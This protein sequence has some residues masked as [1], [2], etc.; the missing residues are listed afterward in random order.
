MVGMDN[1]SVDYF[2]IITSL[3][4]RPKVIRTDGNRV[5]K[6]TRHYLSANRI[7]F[8]SETQIFFNET[9]LVFYFVGKGTITTFYT[10][11]YTIERR[12]S[13]LQEKLEYANIPYLLLVGTLASS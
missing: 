12:Y 1:L 5:T 6:T 9:A 10:L 11:H 4:P 8:G 3:Y 7:V 2:D 13:L